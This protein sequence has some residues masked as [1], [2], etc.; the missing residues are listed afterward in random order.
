MKLWLFLPAALLLAV[1]WGTGMYLFAMPYI[2]RWKKPKGK[3]VNKM[4]E[5]GLV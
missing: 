4:S 3:Q 1:M 5:A 2:A